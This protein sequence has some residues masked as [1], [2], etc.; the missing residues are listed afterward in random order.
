MQFNHGRCGRENIRNREIKPSGTS[1][2][3]SGF[4]NGYVAFSRCG[5][6]LVFPEPVGRNVNMMPSSLVTK[7]PSR[8]ISNVITP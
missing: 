3:S 1:P 4:E 5:E 6:V 8:K 2:T 7:I